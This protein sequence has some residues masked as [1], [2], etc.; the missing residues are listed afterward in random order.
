MIYIL[1]QQESSSLC[2]YYTVN[3][4]S[5]VTNSSRNTVCPGETVLFHCSTNGNGLVWKLS[6]PERESQ[7]EDIASYFLDDDPH[8][9][10]TEG[11]ITAW[12]DG[13]EPLLES[14]VLLHYSPEFHG[15]NVVCESGSNHSIL[16]YKLA[17]ICL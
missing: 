9:Y 17:G 11:P 14:N 10:Y 5:T 7:S 1:K 16:P 12:L 8:H 13:S 2:I 4:S 3:L 6:H 15:Y